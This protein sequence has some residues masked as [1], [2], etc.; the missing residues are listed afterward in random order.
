MSPDS[1]TVAPPVMVMGHVESATSLWEKVIDELII[2]CACR[3]ILNKDNA[4]KRNG[5]FILF[6]DKGDII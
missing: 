2:A 5:F 6:S 3:L 4:R 1:V